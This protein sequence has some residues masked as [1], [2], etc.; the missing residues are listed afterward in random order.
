MAEE[1]TMT[2]GT[3]DAPIVE[4]AVPTEAE[5]DAIKTA[6]FGEG[7]KGESTETPTEPETP[8][9]TATPETPVTEPPVPEPVTP[10]Y[11]QLTEDQLAGLLKLEGKMGKLDEG[12]GTLG[13]LKQ[14]IQQIQSQTTEGKA[15]EVTDED[16]AD[17]KA[18]FPEF[19]DLTKKVLAKVV[20][21]LKGTGSASIDTETLITQ[22]ETRA[23]TRVFK[24]IQQDADSDLQLDH[25][26]WR[27]TVWGDQD[28]GKTEFKDVKTPFTAWLATQPEPVQHRIRNSNNPDFL[29]KQLT[30][31]HE[32]TAKPKPAAP[33]PTKPN[34]RTARLTA[35]V[36]P[37]GVAPSGTPPE[38]NS[39]AAGFRQ[40][41][42]NMGMPV[43]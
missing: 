4:E 27:K 6:A 19:A 20:G 22:A 39:M 18:E 5:L 17:L 3:I 2:T 26:D 38:D 16:M 8:A 31:F 25:P 32:E 13:H 28:D 34:E 35:S 9:A 40:E 21:K 33:T 36:A 30:K 1:T 37:K 43:H 23:E 42:K 10:K 11:A 14:M 7:F 15:V 41:M 24:K 29:S 12:F